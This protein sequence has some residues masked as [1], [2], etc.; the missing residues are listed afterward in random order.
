MAVYALGHSL[1]LLQPFT[2]DPARIA[3]TA[4]RILHEKGMPAPPQTSSFLGSI[5]ATVAGAIGGPP[6]AAPALS[7]GGAEPT[8]PG[9]D[10]MLEYLGLQGR[11]R[12]ANLA[13]RVRAASTLEQ[14]R[15]LA[16]SFAGLPGK[17]TVV[18]L[19]GDASPLNPS[20]MYQMILAD[21]ASETQRMDWQAM[22]RTYEALN[23]AGMSL[24]PVDIR[25]IINP[26]LGG[27][28]ES[29]SHSDFMQGLA[30]SQPSQN[31]P[32]SSTASRRQGEAA[33]AAL[34]IETVAAETG[35]KVFQGSNEISEL[36]LQAQALWSDYYV[37]GFRPEPRPEGGGPVYRRIEVKVNRPGVQVLNRRGFTSRPESSLA[38][39]PEIERE[40]AEAASSPIDLTAIPL[41]LRT[42]PLGSPASPDLRFRL[43][44]P[45][46]ALQHVETPE[47]V[48]YN[49]SIF[50]LVKDRQGKVI[51][52]LGDKIDR[53]FPP[54]QAARIEKTGFAYPGKLQAPAGQRSFG[55]VIVR[56]NLS[57]HMGTITLEVVR[58]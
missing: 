26:G 50:L 53:A 42:E 35:G 30:Q 34:A 24:F 54:A 7:G 28:G 32:Y 21:P 17:K 48:R 56:D 14:F 45:G 43:S 12:E 5:P 37:I 18:W 36:L 31:S 9:T 6:A 49:L 10:A 55:R 8:G 22:A 4:R 33:N 15:E 16:R 44:I 25:G 40:V 13:N 20:L 19:T 38:T 3:D 1:V 51:A 52:S 23:S 29:A 47:G 58:D 41:T 2:H 46:Q 57:G 11:W 39:E 27:A